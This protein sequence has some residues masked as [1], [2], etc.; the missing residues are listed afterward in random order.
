LTRLQRRK[1]VRKHALS[2]FG[3]SLLLAGCGGGSH[4]HVVRVT[5]S[6]FDRTGAVTTGRHVPLEVVL[7]LVPSPL[8]KAGTVC[9][10]IGSVTIE[11]SNGTR[12]RYGRCRPPSI[13]TLQRAVVGEALQWRD[14]PVRR[15]RIVGAS[16]GERRAMRELLAAMQPTLIATIT[17]RPD[18][19]T[20]SSVQSVRGV[21][22]TALFANRYAAVAS[23]RGLPP[24]P[25]VIS[26]D[27]IQAARD[28]GTATIDAGR[29]RTAIVAAI[30]GRARLVELRTEEGALIVVVRTSGTASFL[31]HRGVAFFAA[32]RNV[33]REYVAVQ[34]G[35][36]AVVYAW[37]R[38]PSEGIF[39]ARPDLDACGP[40]QHSMPVGMTEP[41]CPA[42]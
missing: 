15:T 3:V 2:V 9:H 14:V 38:L 1:G 32:T 7:P 42:R 6:T 22:E 12:V 30:R 11:L 21:W 26:G 33:Q 34:D 31:K 35:A 39:Y 36:G 16:A 18:A 28:L 19:M 20:V 41:P 4:P 5:A 27:G 37:G 23:A 29:Y 25:R 13:D 17:I 10:G 8:P 24:V 40:V